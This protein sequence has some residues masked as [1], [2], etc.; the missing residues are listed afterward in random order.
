MSGK[1]MEQLDLFTEPEK[2]KRNYNFDITLQNGSIVNV[3]YKNPCFTDRPHIE[4][5]GLD[6]SETGYKSLFPQWNIYPD[7]TLDKIKEI[8]LLLAEKLH[9]EKNQR[10]H[11]KN[12]V[13]IGGV[14][15]NGK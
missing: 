4:F 5:R 3:N 12:N 7:D 11:K 15:K 14:I 6:I 13:S 10:Q 9:T 2:E 1:I 8:T